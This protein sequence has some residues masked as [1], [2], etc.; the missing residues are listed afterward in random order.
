MNFLESNFAPPLPPQAV[1][2]CTCIYGF[3]CNFNLTFKN[4]RVVCDGLISSRSV[5]KIY[6]VLIDG[7]WRYE[8]K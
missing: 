5:C 2:S 6:Q 1:S 8:H 7:T 3:S 4:L